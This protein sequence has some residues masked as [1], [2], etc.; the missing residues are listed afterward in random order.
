MKFL[1]SLRGLVNELSGLGGIRDKGAA[2]V[3]V[4]YPLNK[5]EIEAAYRSNWMARKAV[6]IPAFDMLREGWSWEA[7]K[8]DIRTI[9]REERKHK[10][11]H[12]LLSAQTLGR[13]YGGGAIYMSDGN[14][15]TEPLN[16]KGRGDL[17]F[18]TVLS[19]HD[20]TS[21]NLNDNAL[22]EFYLEPVMY[23]VNT[24]TE[25]SIRVH[26]SR[27]VRFY[28]NAI[29]TQHAV[30]EDLWS[31]SV[32][33]SV[34]QSIRD[35][36]AGQQGIASLIQEA[37]IDVI[38]M[39]GFMSQ[40]SNAAYRQAVIDRNALA[41]Q[42]KSMTNALMIDSDDEWSQKEVS[43]SALPDVLR[44]L[45]Q[46]V[47]GAAD[48]PVTRFLGQSPAGMTATGESD[49]RNYYDR[50]ASDQELKLRPPMQR[51]MEPLLISALGTAPEE[52]W[53][54]FNPLWQVTD[55]EQSDI[56]KQNSEATKNYVDSGLIPKEVL[57]KA[58]MNQM[59]ETGAWPGLET[60]L[61]EFEA[62]NG[63]IEFP[64]EPEDPADQQQRPQVT[65]WL[66]EHGTP[67]AH[68][69]DSVPTSLYVSRKVINAADI[70]AWAKSQGLKPIPADELHVTIMYSRTA[71][72][73]MAMG[74]DNWNEDGTMT[75]PPGGP[76]VVSKFDG[77]AIV[78]EFSCAPLSWRWCMLK[79]RGCEP[80]H[81]EYA[82][83][84]TIMYD[85][86]DVDI[87]KI[88]PYQGKIELGPEIFAPVNENWKNE[89][90]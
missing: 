11:L 45:I 59:I 69:V 22:D 1:D 10:V 71:V 64:E 26:P 18:L 49:T 13:L 62:A 56:I 46:V 63:P 82:P 33:E 21:G 57:S 8:D 37:K 77:G 84:V 48:I 4:H 74:T 19:R 2:G 67:S 5:F 50:I 3:W 51:V 66:R 39:K 34:E 32:L 42:T 12:K 53:F 60:A 20:L 40:V 29:P 14:D 41:M 85:S 17:K 38:K 28:G 16:V 80:S 52:L 7:D 83:H 27:I 78:L 90:L 25:G 88:V 81:N 70:I 65:D 6:D 72:D 54:K 55:K 58:T 24:R 61:Q 68:I 43:F 73:W 35:A 9:E 89:V 87:S 23:E 86:G 31:D 76:R 15:S 30:Y 47:S 79:E 36:T 44:L 75:V